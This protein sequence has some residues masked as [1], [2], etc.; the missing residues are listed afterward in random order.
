[1]KN[2]SC[3][4]FMTYILLL[5]FLTSCKP[6]FDNHIQNNVFA[7]N[8]YAN[9]ASLDPAFSKDQNSMWVCNMLFN[10]LVQMD[11]QLQI[12]P[13]I[14]KNW[15]ISNDGKI[16]TFYLRDDVYFNDNELFKGKRKVIASDFVYSFNRIVDTNVASTGAW[17][18][19]GKIDSIQP[20]Y[21][22]DDTTFI[23][24][25]NKPFR[26]ML[27][28]LTLPYC[29]VVPP[30]VVDHWGKD[31]RIHPCGTGPF[32]LKKWSENIAMIL[33]RNPHYFELDQSGNHLPYLK[34]VRISFIQDRGV[35]FL[36]FQQGKLDFLN[37][38]DIQYK[39]KLIDIQGNLLPKWNN[40]IT[41]DKM[42]YLNTEYIGISIKEQTNESLLKPKVRKAM[43]LAIDRNKLIKYLRNSIGVAAEAGMIPQGCIGY[44]SMAISRYSYNPDQARK[45]LAEAGYPSGK[46][47]P[48]IILSTNPQYKD[49]MEFIAKNLEDIGVKVKIDVMQGGMLREA[50][51]KR[52][53]QMFR[54]SWIGDYPDAENFLALFYSE[55][56]APPN[57]TGFSDVDFDKL[58]K[59]MIQEIDDDKAQMLYKQMNAIILEQAPVIPLYYDEVVRFRPLYVKG[60]TPNA[61]NMLDLRKVYFDN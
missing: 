38:L 31:F 49:L 21:A 1:M 35:E 59:K 45:L 43:N 57:Y 3:M 16:Y 48:E 39:D 30:E 58:Y 56:D 32:F 8:L 11:S 18:F 46:G 41:M 37:A 22:A 24:R 20:F 47:L 4:K 61:M 23:L 54:A 27:G 55:Y 7:L 19:N 60:L 26:P 9:L 29:A 17:L 44:D 2:C 14:A 12:Q 10:G 51:R 53:L 34:G 6:S 15:K 36:A 5:F 40:M 50:M 42:P 25:L 28:M 52:S 33:S 13:S